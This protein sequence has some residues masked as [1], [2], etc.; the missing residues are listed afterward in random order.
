[1]GVHS[2]L[3]RGLSLATAV[4]A[5]LGVSLV[6]VGSASADTTVD[7]SA[8]DGQITLKNAVAGHKYAAVE[9]ATY[10]DATVNG[11]NKVSNIS[12]ATVPDLVA[13]AESALSAVNH[14]ATSDP[15]YANNPVGE[16]ASKW[17]GYASPGSEDTVSNSGSAADAWGRDGKLRQFVTILSK[18][19]TFTT[20]VTGST[21]TVTPAADGDASLSSLPEGLYIISDVTDVQGSTNTRINSIPMLVGTTVGPDHITDFVSGMPVGTINIKD[22][23]NSITKELIQTDADR[24]ASVSIGD[25]LHYRLT[26][27]VPL[28]TGFNPD[29]FVYKVTD[30]PGKGLDFVSDEAHPVVVKARSGSDAAATAQDAASYIVTPGT[31]TDGATGVEFDLTKLVVNND[32]ATRLT[33]KDPITIDYYMRVNDSAQAGKLSNSAKLTFSNQPGGGSTGTIVTPDTPTNA[34]YFYNFKIRK[35]AKS[36]GAALTNA[37]FSVTRSDGIA[38]L[39]FNEQSAGKYMLAMNQSA[40]A[41]GQ[42]QTTV[43]KTDNT[44]TLSVD[45]LS[46]GKYSVAET[47]QPDGYSSAFKPT[48]NVDIALE[49]TDSKADAS[50]PVITNEADAW[51]LVAATTTN[52]A[53]VSQPVYDANHVM[54]SPWSQGFPNAITVNNVKSISQLPLTGGA[55]IILAVLLAL[56]LAG[57]AGVLIVVRNRT[58]KMRV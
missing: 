48:F 6:G 53:Q 38:P 45:G 9:I 17:L 3:R 52:Q 7:V 24:G 13:D 20:K 49:K 28:T 5:L 51:G 16:V 37:E 26:L 47:K 10:Q 56:V 43:L 18:T 46:A 14:G 29:T 58:N 31:P 44:G 8:N 12:I 15:A 36:D 42:N 40:P 57:A 2:Q 23:E 35:V 55:G 22:D 11:D 32:P 27:K 50:K 41:T 33:W 54:T 19:S 30:T 4:A 39:W 34:A 21:A 25:Y 1:M